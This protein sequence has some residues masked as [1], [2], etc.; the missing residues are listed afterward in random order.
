MPDSVSGT[1]APVDS[2]YAVRA[3]KFRKAGKGVWLTPATRTELPFDELIYYWKVR[4][5]R[6]EGFR[7]YLQVG[8][9]GGDESPWLYAG[10]WGVVELAGERSNPRFDRGEI[11]QDHLKLKGKAV[12]FRFKV[13]EGGNKPLTVLPDLGV[14]TTSNIPGGHKDAE[15]AKPRQSSDATTRVLAIPLRKQEDSAGNRLPDRCQSAALASALQYFGTTV[16]LEQIICHNTDPEYR[17]FGIW[18]RTINAAVEL[19]FD[20]YLDR[21]RDWDSVRAAVANN[22]VILCSITMPAGGNYLAPPYPKMSGHIV[23]LNGVTLDGRVIVTDSALSAKNEGERLQWLLPDFE[24]VWMQNKGGV[25]MVICPPK[26]AK[27][28][29]VAEI[30]PFPR[31]MGGQTTGTAEA[32]AVSDK[33]T[34]K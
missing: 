10:Y 26:G 20:A 2:R 34:T 21:F 24:K 9:G 5:P 30:I 19:G 33:L 18:P 13:V 15:T 11:D 27:Q 22:K 16:P 3:G 28:R 6:D 4:L 17:A 32:I 1:T 7:L 8:F 12:R 23:A 29:L 14:I 31:A 25:G